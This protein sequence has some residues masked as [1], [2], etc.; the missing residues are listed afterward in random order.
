MSYL[1][2]LRHGQSMWNQKNRFTGWVDVPLSKQGINEALRAGE[3]LKHISFHTIFTSK[4]LR[5][6]QTAMLAI[7]QNTQS[8]TPVVIHN[9]D[10]KNRYNHMSQQNP[11]FLAVYYD[12]RLNERFYGNLQGLDKNQCREEFG[13][14]QV[15]IWRRSYDVAP[16]N[17]ES[18]ALTANRTLPCFMERIE[19]ELKAGKNILLSAHGNSLRSIVMHLEKLNKTQVLQLEIP[20]GEP[21]AYAYDDNQYLAIDINAIHN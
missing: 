6:Q 15:K 18:L 20:T 16:P 14:E 5:A 1:I 3:Q 7:S 19:P 10:T 13:E 2:L 4:L 11:E 8:H 9:D 21:R 17:G 12:W